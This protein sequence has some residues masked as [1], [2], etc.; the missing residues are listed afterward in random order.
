[1]HRV[2]YDIVKYIVINFNRIYYVL[3]LFVGVINLQKLIALWS[4]KN[5]TNILVSNK[6]NNLFQYREL[7]NNLSAVN[8]A[9]NCFISNKMTFI[10]SIFC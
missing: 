1:M 8:Y 3:T 9:I 7:M 4:T 6:I 5:G 2:F 10:M